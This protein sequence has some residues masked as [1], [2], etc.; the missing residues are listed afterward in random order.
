MSGL[1]GEAIPE[2]IYE[3]TEPRLDRRDLRDDAARDVTYTANIDNDIE[4]LE[5][6]IQNSEFIYDLAG[7]NVLDTENLKGGVYIINGCKV[8]VGD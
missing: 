4:N 7:R 2:Y 3:P 5:F 6:D 1:Y 8:M